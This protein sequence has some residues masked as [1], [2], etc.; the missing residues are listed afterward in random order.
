MKF[1]HKG[2]RKA[3]GQNVV[4]RHKGRTDSVQDDQALS[5]ILR[6]SKLYIMFKK[7]IAAGLLGSMG[8][9]NPLPGSEKVLTN[10]VIYEDYP[11][12]DVFR[13]G[14]VFYYSSSSFAFSPGAPVLK[15]YD[16][17]NWTPVSHSVPRLDFGD[18][19]DIA[20]ETDRAYVKGIW[21]SGMRYRESDD[22]FYW[23]GCVQSTGKTYVYTSPGH[24]AL[25]KN[26]EV[27]DWEWS[28]AGVIDKCY[29]DNGIFFD[30]DD[31]LYVS[32][33]NRELYVVELDNDFSEVRSEM[34][35]DS[36]EDIYLEGSHFYKAKGY[37][38]VVPTQVASGE[39]ALRSKDPFGPY[40]HRVFWNGLQGPLSNAGYAHQGGM[41]DLPNGDWWFVAFMDAYP[42]GR[43]PV[44]APIEWD[45]DDWPSIKLDS[46]GHWGVNYPMPISTHRKVPSMVGKDKFKGPKLD[47]NWEWNHN[48]DNE[49]WEFRKG[50][51]LVL[52]TASVTEDFFSARNSLTRRAVG[53][54]AQATFEIDIRNMKDGDRAGAAFFRAQAAYI[55]IHKTGDDARLVMVDGLQ[56]NAT[57]SWQTASN[58]T[59]QAEGPSVSGDKVFLRIDADITPAFGLSPVREALFSYSN[60]GKTWTQLGPAYLLSNSWQFFSAFR[61]TA[62]NFATK[63]LGGS[64]TLESFSVEVLE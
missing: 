30:E 1:A 28:R 21:A 35:Y 57:S 25:E 42:A 29:Y 63:E 38:W 2:P 47:E 18:E 58:G 10:P 41:V 17:V 22:K 24:G 40:D 26:G 9:A 49:A 45:A 16:L 48:P 5:R 27:Q 3:N 54:H 8:L 39:W 37:Y 60:D 56:L 32:Y 34:I 59:I 33:G 55:G 31:K 61:Y 20:N 51:G 53:P 36:G 46:N 62:F 15:S 12:I 11:D 44:V 43:M 6:S 13:V 4:C 50:G 52:R 7:L 19:Y 23:M 14:D 64:V